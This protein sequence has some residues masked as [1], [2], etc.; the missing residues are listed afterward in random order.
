VERKS[1]RI[2]RVK[3]GTTTLAILAALFASLALA[4]DF[5]TINGR[6]C[7]NAT[8]S[9]V[10]ADGMVLKT[11]SGITKLYFTELPKEVQERFH[12]GSATPTG[13]AVTHA[14]TRPKAPSTPSRSSMPISLR[15]RSQKTRQAG[16]DLTGETH[17]RPGRVDGDTRV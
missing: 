7:K 15:N 8:V 17:A 3:Y 9:R 12:H 11:K 13:K 4:E 2:R 6:E 5:K 10:E 14:S 1:G 16:I